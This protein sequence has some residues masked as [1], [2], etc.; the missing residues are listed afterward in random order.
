[1]NYV[2]KEELQ[3]TVSEIDDK[4]LD[5]VTRVDFNDALQQF[6]EGLKIENKETYDYIQGVKKYMTAANEEME[7]VRHEF[8]AFEKKLILKA[9]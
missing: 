1:M 2:S 5:R 6:D 3:T 7:R 9:D 8:K 4:L